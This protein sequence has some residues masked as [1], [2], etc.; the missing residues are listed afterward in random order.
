VPYLASDDSLRVLLDLPAVTPT[1]TI[2]LDDLRAAQAE[3]TAVPLTV[4][5]REAIISIKHELEGEGVAASDRRWRSTA[6]LVRAKAWLEGE[7]Q[8]SS[9]HAE[10]LVHAL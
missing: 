9:D 4:D 8:T 6:K 10:I 3:V 2:T 5:T 1:A 7:A